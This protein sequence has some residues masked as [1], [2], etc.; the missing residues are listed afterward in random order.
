M[1]R[2]IRYSRFQ[3]RHL[4]EKSTE[5]LYKLLLRL[6]I[7]LCRNSLDLLDR[8]TDKIGQ[9]GGYAR[10]FET[11]LQETFKLSPKTPDIHVVHWQR[12]QKDRSTNSIV[13]S[14]DLLQTDSPLSK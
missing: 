5:A 7:Q 1:N 3:I 12:I 10:E 4:F 6:S 14:R 13:Q 11:I 2:I 8:I 9:P